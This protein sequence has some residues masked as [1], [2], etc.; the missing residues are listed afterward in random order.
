MPQEI[1]EG[2]I[3]PGNLLGFEFGPDHGAWHWRLEKNQAPGRICTTT[4]EGHPSGLPLQPHQQGAMSDREIES[5]ATD[6][7][8]RPFLTFKCVFEGG[9]PFKRIF[10]FK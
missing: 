10:A 5:S 1:L 7:S 2:M 3:H 8:C 6:E 9:I 4:S